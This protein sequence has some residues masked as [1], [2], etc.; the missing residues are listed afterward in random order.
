MS[1]EINIVLVKML[2]RLHM[3]GTLESVLS[4]FVLMAV[5]VFLDERYSNAF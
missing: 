5:N 4:A 1:D 2:C 3:A